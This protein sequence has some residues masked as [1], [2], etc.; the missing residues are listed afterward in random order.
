M[1]LRTL[2]LAFAI[3]TLASLVTTLSAGQPGI[4]EAKKAIRLFEG[5]PKLPLPEP[6]VE[7]NTSATIGKVVYVFRLPNGQTYHVSS[8]QPMFANP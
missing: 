6:K 3:T 1:R 7:Y 4:E 8:N 2:P 5:L